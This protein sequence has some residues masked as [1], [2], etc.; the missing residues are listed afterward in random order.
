MVGDDLKIFVHGLPLDCE[1][2]SLKDFLEGEVYVSCVI[3]IAIERRDSN[4]FLQIINSSSL[5][6]KLSWISPLS[7]PHS[8][9]LLTIT[10]TVTHSHLFNQIKYIIFHV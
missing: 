1:E 2:H 3:N 5:S 9:G 6:K 8:L 4:F 7:Y 10:D